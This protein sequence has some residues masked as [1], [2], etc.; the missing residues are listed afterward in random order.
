[1]LEWR[2]A[3]GH[4]LQQTELYFVMQG[5]LGDKISATTKVHI[6]P[7]IYKAALP[8]VPHQQGNDSR[9]YM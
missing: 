3:A 8:V 2:F 5:E 4:N 6:Q 7:N 1:M 9:P